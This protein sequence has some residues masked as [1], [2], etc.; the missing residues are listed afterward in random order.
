[1]CIHLEEQRGYCSIKKLKVCLD[2]LKFAW[3]QKPFK[4]WLAICTIGIIVGLLLGMGMTHLVLLVAI[5]CIG[6]GLEIANGAMETLLDIVHPTYSLKVKIVKDAFAAV[7]VFVF[8]AY[9]ISWLILVSP[10]L[11]RWIIK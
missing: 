5:A 10:L 1:M 7:C 4:I 6:W 2:A 3:R 8:G 9:I 11:W